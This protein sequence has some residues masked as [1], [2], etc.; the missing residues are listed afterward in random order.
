MWEEHPDYQ[1]AQM[2]FI[3]IMVA[4]GI[5]VCLGWAVFQRD[6][7]LFRGISLVVGGVVLALL[8]LVGLVRLVVRIL[9]RRHGYDGRNGKRINQ[10][11]W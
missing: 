5:G 3:G 7:E 1:K 8:I 4:V 9:S 6:W 10:D 2:R 11:N